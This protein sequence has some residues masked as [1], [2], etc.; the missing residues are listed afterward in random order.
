MFTSRLA[1]Q[2]IS[3]FLA[4]LLSGTLGVL[5]TAAAEPLSSRISQSVDKLNI[6]TIN[7]PPSINPPAITITPPS[8]NAPG[9][10]ISESKR[11]GVG[12]DNGAGNSNTDSSD[13]DT[14]DN[15]STSE[16]TEET[17][18]PATESLTIYYEA[19]EDTIFV[20]Q[21]DSDIGG[22]VTF[23]EVAQALDRDD[24]LERTGS[25][26]WMLRAN[27]MVNGIEDAPG[28]L[29][30][31][32][33]GETVRLKSDSSGFVY[34]KFFNSDALI[35][36][37]AITSWDEG[38]GGPDIDRSD[39]RSYVLARY[40]GRMDVIS[41]DIGYLG[42]SAGE[43]YGISWR[44]PLGEKDQYTI[45]GRV[46]DSTIHHNHFG[47]YTHSAEKMVIQNNV[48]H[49]NHVYGI[50]PHDDSNNLLID[51]NEVYGNGT[52]GIII[53]KRCL[54]N[55][56]SN[57]VTYD[58][59]LAG[60][61]LDKESD[62][63]VVEFNT[64]YGNR[65][66]I[67]IYG[68]SDN[69]IRN[70]N[71]HDNYR[72][73]IA[74]DN[75][76]NN[77]IYDNT[78]INHDTYGFYL[79]AGADRNTIRQNT[80]QNSQKYNVYVKTSGNEVADNDLQGGTVGIYLYT[81]AAM[82]NIISNNTV[83]GS[84]RD[85]ISL[86]EAEDTIVQGN[87]IV[88]STEKGV[89]LRMAQGSLIENNMIEKNGNDGLYFYDGSTDNVLTGN[90]INDNGDAGVYLKDVTNNRIEN[91]TFSNNASYG[92]YSYGSTEN[93]FTGDTFENNFK[94]YYY[95]KV[96]SDNIIYVHDERL[97]AKVGTD[98]SVFRIIQEEGRV[99]RTND[100]I[101]MN[102]TPDSV[103]AELL[104][105]HNVTYFDPSSLIITPD[106]GTPDGQAQIVEWHDNAEGTK[107]VALNIGSS[108]VSIDKLYSSSPYVVYLDGVKL[109]DIF[110]NA[111]GILEFPFAGTSGTQVLGIVNG[112]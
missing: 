71:I 30:F 44:V 35:E 26:Q 87:H 63:N 80:V 11:S 15:D 100:D 110:S 101:V 62:G 107:Q 97:T 88:G 40:D 36:D 78:I 22:T 85:G 74:K 66:G 41:S 65:D 81:I 53:S 69:T 91:N 104:Y 55:T 25:N 73:I 57:N 108:T 48:V 68:S 47:I 5:T 89:V 14:T 9:I 77:D 18:E 28:R 42:Y 2:G 54:N 59:A 111:D 79:R 84:E 3:F 16:P 32:I 70:N 8:I 27:L 29:R 72:G 76:H 20:E 49:S 1:R 19:S 4:I 83:Q 6:P 99:M 24:L 96:G 38:A 109:M 86:R 103:T 46:E 90:S 75:S 43:S 56:I 95:N 34:M 98:D 112:G 23:T 82:G 58:N 21:N 12:I 64:A 45:T 52:H 31:E 61:M 67:A 7:N 102:I 60:I 13:P 93:E 39:G 106:A 50:D 105:R 37:A 17:N 92:V 51:G 33:I 94:D 10:S